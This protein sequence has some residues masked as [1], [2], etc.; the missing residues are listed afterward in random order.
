VIATPYGHNGKQKPVNFEKLMSAEAEKSCHRYWSDAAWQSSWVFIQSLQRF[1][2]NHSIY[3]NCCQPGAVA[4]DF[5]R[6][7]VT[8]FGKLAGHGVEKM[9]FQPIQVGALPNCIWPPIR[10]QKARGSVPLACCEATPV[11]EDGVEQRSTG[12]GRKVSLMMR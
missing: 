4:S 7:V 9:I 2:V 1:L 11:A 10:R 3:V 8:T 6:D 5:N 12:I